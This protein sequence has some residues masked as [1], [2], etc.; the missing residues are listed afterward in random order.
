MMKYFPP[1][2]LKTKY[3]N[4]IRYYNVN[5]T[6]KLQQVKLTRGMAGWENPI[7]YTIVP[8]ADI[9]DL[10]ND[11]RP[12][13]L[14]KKEDILCLVFAD[15]VRAYE[16]KDTKNT[17][18]LF[19]ILFG[20]YQANTTYGITLDPT[21]QYNML[22]GI[23]DEKKRV[24]FALQIFNDDAYDYFE[25][26]TNQVVLIE[27]DKTDFDKQANFNRNLVEFLEQDDQ[28]EKSS[29]QAQQWSKSFL[30]ALQESKQ[31]YGSGIEWGLNL[32]LFHPI[33]QDFYKG[34]KK[35]AEIPVDTFIFAN[36]HRK[37]WFK[38][39]SAHVTTERDRITR[40]TKDEV[41]RLV[42]QAKTYKLEDFRNIVLSLLTKYDKLS[43]ETT[44]DTDYPNENDVMYALS[45]ELQDDFTSILNVLKG[46]RKIDGLGTIPTFTKLQDTLADPLAKDT[47]TPW[48]VRNID[49]GR[50]RGY[51]IV[52]LSIIGKIVKDGKF[53]LSTN[54]S[55][56]TTLMTEINAKRGFDETKW[57]TDFNSVFVVFDDQ[58][59][60]AANKLKLLKDRYNN[61]LTEY[62][63]VNTKMTTSGYERQ[64]LL[65]KQNLDDAKVLVR[66]LNESNVLAQESTVDAKLKEVENDADR[67]RLALAQS[68]SEQVIIDKAGADL[69][70][71][72]NEW[73]NLKTEYQRETTTVYGG[74]DPKWPDISVLITT[75]TFNEEVAS[76]NKSLEDIRNNKIKTLQLE[77]EKLKEDA[78]K[79]PLV[80]STRFDIPNFTKKTELINYF[81]KNS[82]P[83]QGVN[84][85]VDPAWIEDIAKDNKRLTGLLHAIWGQENNNSQAVVRGLNMAI[86]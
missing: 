22:F 60:G 68:K 39:L 26:E 35:R 65:P 48:G 30:K 28:L 29:P 78:D 10:P 57:N 44:R 31:D 55:K 63:V 9:T 36:G 18:I 74:A 43:N 77:I 80:D 81:T 33:F 61:L 70:D 46:E 23:K 1:G 69:S 4:K 53:Q 13:W 84:T 11:N 25:F 66:T 3:G 64:Y 47:I 51:T 42:K 86:L 24:A 79:L 5:I 15:E 82:N 73:N 83:F 17:E 75:N 67:W 85:N 71:A 49:Y 6:E 20:L 45:A 14:T 41:D 2:D 16:P 50:A 58:F 34:E 40:E 8:Q 52:L 76:F 12:K 54:S 56:E 32:A 59:R 38:D 72:Q 21:A 19:Q 27:P 7:E 37:D 62:N